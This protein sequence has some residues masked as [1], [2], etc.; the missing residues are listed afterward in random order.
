MLSRDT[1]QERD[2]W[3]IRENIPVALNREGVLHKYDVSLPVSAMDDLVRHVR[4]EFHRRGEIRRVVGYGHV[5][6]GNLHLNVVSDPTMNYSTPI[7]KELDAE[8]YEYTKDMRGSIAGE[9][10]LGTLKKDK[11]FYSKPVLA[12]EYMKEMKTLFDP[13]GI[14]NPGKV[15][16]HTIPPESELP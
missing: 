4:R 1:K 5:G 16:P 8:V 12:V 15:L 3:K 7:H 13:R 10:G 11:I 2:L 14:L 9:H 6:D